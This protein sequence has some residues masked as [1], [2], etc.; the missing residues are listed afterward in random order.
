M[1][2]LIFTLM[3]I[4]LM[5]WVMIASVS[6]VNPAQAQVRER[7]SRVE[8]ALGGLKAGFDEY[9]AATGLPA[10]SLA[11]I[12][13]AYTFLPAAPSGMSWSYG[14]VGNGRF[15]CLSGVAKPYDYEGLKRLSGVL[16]P[17]AY[18]INGSCGATTNAYPQSSGDGVA[19]A[20]TY[21]VAP[22]LP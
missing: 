11:E 12:T 19:V 18:F 21:W 1:I 16:S 2:N 15:F 3:S 4:A 17:Q 8:A 5:G 10:S 9:Q 22:N 7:A 20:A 14:G 13:P 6:Y